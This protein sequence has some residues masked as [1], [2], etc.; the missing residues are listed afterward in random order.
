MRT[1]IKSSLIVVCAMPLL[2][3]QNAL[4]AGK[5]E[6]PDPGKAMVT[7]D[8]KVIIAGDALDL[9]DSEIGT[10]TQG[11]ETTLGGAA[12]FEKSNGDF[13]GAVSYGKA[14]HG[15]VWTRELAVGNGTAELSSAA[16]VPTGDRG[17]EMKYVRY[18]IEIPA[19]TLI[20]A[21]FRAYTGR[22]MSYEIR[23]GGPLTGNE[24][25][26]QWIATGARWI[27]FTSGPVDF[28]LDLSPAG[29]WGLYQEDPSSAYKGHL[30]RNGD[31]YELVI[32]TNGAQFGVRAAQKIVIRPDRADIDAIHPIHRVHYQYPMPVT[33]R[34]Q[35]TAG[36]VAD[37]FFFIKDDP[38]YDQPFIP[39]RNVGYDASRGMGWEGPASGRLIT[40]S[41]KSA[42][43]PI[44]GGGWVNQGKATFRIDHPNA[45]VLVNV[46]LSGLA[47]KG[48]VEIKVSGNPTIK[49]AAIQSNG[50]VTATVPARITDGR[51]EVTLDGK[52]WMLSGIVVQPL[53]YATEDYM[54]TRCWWALGR[55]P[56]RW[57]R[58]TDVAHW[59]I[60]PA[61]TFGPA[62]LFNGTSSKEMTP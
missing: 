35:F 32:P 9:S 44:F 48:D 22:H 28:S 6:I 43:G 7:L 8:G 5:L 51:L 14:P 40:A 52:Q 36:K 23:S 37:G 50:R 11:T 20:G 29:P 33:R 47:T 13:Q 45:T 17:P 16:I 24:P 10:P 26:D 2:C 49:T 57:P 58:F 61:D 54:F 42:Y 56:W 30:H 4:G 1:I 18:K 25:A 21:H 41:E 55:E 15:I 12:S 27:Q 59:S 39:W 46:L 19:K 62:P 38:G 53:F 60:W 3:L 34:V 31:F